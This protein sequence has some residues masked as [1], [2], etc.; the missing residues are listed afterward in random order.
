MRAFLGTV[1]P[2][3][4]RME[5]LPASPRHENGDTGETQAGPAEHGAEAS[6]ELDA[7][8]AP[9]HKTSDGVCSVSLRRPGYTPQAP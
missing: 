6:D 5:S 1:D 2:M 8:N 4:P 7:S 3:V 9:L